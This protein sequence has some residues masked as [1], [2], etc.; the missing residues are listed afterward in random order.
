MLLKIHTM[1]GVIWDGEVLS[2]EVPTK[3]WQIGIL[4][5]HNPLTS[6]VSPGVLKLLPKEQRWSEFLSETDFLFEDEKI[7]M[8]IGDWFLYT[9]GQR[10]ELFVI[11]A[12]TNPES[13][14]QVLQ[15]MQEKLQEDIKQI[16]A[17]GNLD[18][19]ER[20]YLNLQKLKADIKLVRIKERYYK[21]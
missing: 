12:T 21:N 17:E 7:A 6:I 19:V 16:K 9:D 15:Q 1:K 4:P 14:A 11:K 13:D 18:E 2:V 8:A 20:A 3:T 5:Q 10:I